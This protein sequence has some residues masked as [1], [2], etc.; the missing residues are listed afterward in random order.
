PERKGPDFAGSAL[1]TLNRLIDD[2][3]ATVRLRVGGRWLGMV[4]PSDYGSR[5]AF[6]PPTGGELDLELL[7]RIR[8]RHHQLSVEFPD[9]G[10]HVDDYKQA[11]RRVEWARKWL[12]GSQP[13]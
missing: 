2:T 12:R 6:D 10:D 9:E 8:D 13:T 11:K 3:P 7:E 4:F 5:V 1:V